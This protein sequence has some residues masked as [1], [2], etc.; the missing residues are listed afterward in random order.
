MKLGKESRY[1]IE[2]LV[3]LA[4]TPFGTTM[5]LRDIADGGG[6]PQ[7]F[8][9]KI[10]QK[11]KRANIVAS[12]HGAVRGYALARRAKAINVKDILLAVEGSDTFD[13][14]VFWSDR[15]AEETPCPMHIHWK[16]VRQTIAAL[17]ERTTVA[18]LARHT[19]ARIR[20]NPSD[21]DETPDIRFNF[22]KPDHGTVGAS[23]S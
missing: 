16:R 11:L 19:H 7:N 10:F 18:N 17:M 2:G 6:V 12:S 3:V 23:H 20:F 21:T 8:L 5:Q 9:A 14:C 15:C 22:K 1:A 13:R 4:R